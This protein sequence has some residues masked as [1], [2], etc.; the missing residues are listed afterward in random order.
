[1]LTRIALRS[2]PST[3]SPST[4]VDQSGTA[5]GRVP[6]KTAPRREVSGTR[7][8][9]HPT[10]QQLEEELTS[11]LAAALYMSPGDIHREKPFVELGLD[12]IVGV[13]WTR[14]I[15]VR[16]GL[17]L[18]ATRLYDHPTI[19]VLAKFMHG[20]IERRTP[21]VSPAQI[22]AAPVDPVLEQVTA[23]TV[24][25]V[26][27]PPP[28]SHGS[29]RPVVLPPPARATAP[30]S[31]LEPSAIVGMSG[32]YPLS[33]DLERYWDTLANGRN[34]VREIPRWRWNVDEFY[35]PQPQTRGKVYCKWLGT[36]DDIE[37]FDPLFFNISP[38]DAELMDPQQRLFLEESYKA[39]EDAGCAPRRLSNVNCGVYLGIMSNEYTS[40]LHKHR[41]GLGDTTGNSAAVA[42]ARIAYYLNL[43][44]P[45]IPVDTACSSSLVA[46]HLACQAL[47]DGEID[48]A[49]AGGVTLYLAPELYLGMCAAAMLAPDGQCKTFDD[50]ADGFVPGE[51]VGALVLKRLGDAEA[52]G[53]RIHGVIIGSGIN[54]DGRTNGLT[55][56]SAT[57]QMDLERGIYR[58]YD[59]DPETISY[60]EAH[61]TGTKL[62]D[63][64][65][66]EALAAVYGERTARKEF[67]AIGSVK[68]NVGHTSAAAGMASVHKVLLQIRERQLAP[69]LNF[70]TPNQHFDFA[71]SPFYVNT[72]L[73]AWE[74]LDGAPRRAAIS[75]FGIS[76]TNAH[77]VVEE[78]V[79]KVAAGSVGRSFP[80][81][82]VIV[83]LSARTPAQLRAHAEQMR[84]Y[85]ERAGA[86]D[87]PALAYTLQVAR[88]PLEHRLALVA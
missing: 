13:E 43:K 23:D 84:R 73:K 31:R 2:L 58:R 28:D 86:T 74:A 26:Q 45:A 59:I 8:A 37:C 77:L 69:T 18:R 55:A 17:S 32:R 52:A 87:L 82:S 78:Y 34:G 79:P 47:R 60:V 33:P 25:P 67:C 5:G 21:Q 24:A 30:A 66:L 41:P 1:M 80:N 19:T 54:Q 53:D 22:D 29:S 11:S 51:G 9:P 39:F 75:S 36:L 68:S 71:E 81:E 16:H 42:A 85:L 49:L 10:L 72:R 4:P 27:A 6:E 57:S 3:D 76:G 7:T 15:N 14:A 38:A 50:A 64:I 46:T 65:E 44:G 40:L 70:R 61:G 56:P 12:S 48:M 88:D 20:E 35:D 62:G 63:P 83:V